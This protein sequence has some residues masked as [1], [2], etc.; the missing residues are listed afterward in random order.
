MHDKIDVTE[1]FIND[2]V[3]FSSYDN[4]RK[5]ASMIDGQKNAS[6]K[7]LYTILEK[8]IKSKI[9]VSQLG[10]KVSEFTEYLHGSLDG[11]IVNL[12]QDYTGTNNIP[13]LQ[14]KGNFG[15]RF[16]Q[17]ASASRY[18][19]SYGTDDFF[20]LF[21]KEDTFILKQQ[22]FEGTKIE[23]RYYVPT[24]PILLINGSEGV[25][26]G[27]A[28]KI[29]PRNTNDIKKYIISKLNGRT[30]RIKLTPY[31]NN[32]N[33]SIDNGNTV[34]QW[35]IKGVVKRISKNKVRIS[36]VPIGYDLK[37]YIKV[38]DI[39][40][41]KN[42]IQSY[43][44]KSEN[45]KFLFEVTIPSKI[46][47]TWDDA[48]ILSNLKLIKKVTEN[49]TIVDENNKIRVFENITE[50][51]D[52]YYSIKLYYMK[53]RKVFLIKD[54]I[55]D[56]KLLKSK[57]IF[58]KLVVSKKLKIMNRKTEE[59]I[60]DLKKIKKIEP[61]DGSYDFLLKMSIS[62]ITIEKQTK[63][64]QDILKYKDELDKLKNI[65][66]QQMWLNDI[67]ELKN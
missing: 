20:N 19:Y 63:M 17:E 59:I 12:A 56:I 6:R 30:S 52:R 29:L 66:I 49:Y 41:D 18:I 8:N 7:I 36:E 54:L 33:G 50:I 22:F 67:K 61:V 28:Q 3:N 57:I 5:I 53:K 40:E 9:K 45:D 62:A 46:L 42:I 32:F 55:K 34:K 1:F 47:K 14:K 21:N 39:L 24:L 37:S 10:S 27:F 11:V 60:N 2:Y 44:D 38:L 65:S 31:Y 43:K 35:E 48:T 58:I 26:S 51:I 25:S 16:N 64:M 4:L 23:P 13:L 15:T